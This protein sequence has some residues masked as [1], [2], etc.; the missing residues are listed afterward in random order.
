M[1][2]GYGQGQVQGQGGYGYPAAAHNTRQQGGGDD[3]WEI[4]PSPQQ[5][6]PGYGIPYPGA[7]GTGYPYPGGQSGTPVPYAPGPY[8]DDV[9][10]NTP[11]GPQP[12]ASYASRTPTHVYQ[13][14]GMG[15]ANNATPHG[16]LQATRM[17]LAGTTPVQPAAGLT[18]DRSLNFGELYSSGTSP[19]LLSRPNPA[20]AGASHDG[21]AVP[22]DVTVNHRTPVARTHA[23]PQSL[24]SSTNRINEQT[25]SRNNVGSPP[26]AVSTSEFGFGRWSVDPGATP[27]PRRP[28]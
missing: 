22:A 5:G 25:P 21:F 17:R 11:T 7:N 27:Q 1:T 23:S 13:S 6:H 2:P 14:N 15:A 8:A 20:S 28:Q 3:S 10:Y 18:S 9:R 16:S 4:N 26:K 12:V 24:V 19:P